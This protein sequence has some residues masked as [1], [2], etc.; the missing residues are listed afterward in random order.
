[1]ILCLVFKIQ[2]NDTIYSLNYVT[3]QRGNHA[4]IHFLAT[5]LSHCMQRITR[6]NKMH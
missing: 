2:T 3:S 1:M 6:T 5:K 4:I